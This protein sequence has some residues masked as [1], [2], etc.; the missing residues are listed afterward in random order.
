MGC[1][2]HSN[3]FGF[4]YCIDQRIWT[5]QTVVH[6]RDIFD[7]HES[8][9]FLSSVF[10]FASNDAVLVQEVKKTQKKKT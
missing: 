3:Q 9:P 10:T 5:S 7:L 1:G 8:R 2:I 4:D 6:V